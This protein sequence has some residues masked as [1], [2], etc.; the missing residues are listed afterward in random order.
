MFRVRY[1]S[2]K[3]PGPGDQMTK[4]IT[5][6]KIKELHGLPYP[7]QGVYWEDTNW[8]E[9]ANCV[10]TNWSLYDDYKDEGILIYADPEFECDVEKALAIEKAWEDYTFGR[11]KRLK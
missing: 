1:I 5:V 4:Y 2:V 6:N 7:A 8:Y 10:A 11:L 9:C 3:V